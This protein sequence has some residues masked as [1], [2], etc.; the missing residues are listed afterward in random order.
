VFKILATK[1]QVLTVTAYPDAVYACFSRP[2]RLSQSM[3][4]V[5]R[6]ELLRGSKVWWVLK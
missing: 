2:E 6:G 5:K 3:A 4:S 1:E